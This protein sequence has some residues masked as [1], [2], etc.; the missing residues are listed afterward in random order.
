VTRRIELNDRRFHFQS[1]RMRDSG[2]QRQRDLIHTRSLDGVNRRQDG[3]PA[4]QELPNTLNLVS[5]DQIS[6][7]RCGLQRVSGLR[8]GVVWIALYRLN[9]G[10][11]SDIRGSINGALGSRKSNSGISPV[12][13]QPSGLASTS[14]MTLPSGSKRPVDLLPG[15]W[16]HRRACSSE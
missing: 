5:R 15:F 16:C 1:K 12:L 7:E 4:V 8:C 6:D 3:M 10:K 11:N 9:L 2:R 14:P 13:Q